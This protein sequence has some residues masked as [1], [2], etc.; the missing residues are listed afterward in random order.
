MIDYKDLGSRIR[1]LR[2]RQSMTQEEL[3]EKAGV[4]ASFMGH[5]ERGTRVASLETLV[6]LCN[7]LKTSPQHL[8]AASL[9]D[10]LTY[11]IPAKYTPE[12][13]CKLSTFLRMADDVL[14][15]W[16]DDSF[17]HGRG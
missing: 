6:S 1:E 11:H 4:S 17:G 15:N 13:R 8:L 7:A 16:G 14:T 9:D 5:I 12:E 10:E 2:R 3:A